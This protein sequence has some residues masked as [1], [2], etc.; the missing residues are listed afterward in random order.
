[1]GCIPS[2][3]LLPILDTAEE[4]RALGHCDVA[5]NIYRAFIDDVDAFAR[6][7]KVSERAAKTLEADARYLIDHCP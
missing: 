7:G 4:Q 2:R 1:M 3:S 5:A 6:A